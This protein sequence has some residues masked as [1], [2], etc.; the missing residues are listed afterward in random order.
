M[1]FSYAYGV[2]NDYIDKHHLNAALNKEA[3]WRKL[4]ATDKQLDLLRRNNI[5][6]SENITRGEASDLLNKPTPKQLSYIK[7][8]RLHDVPESLTK[9][10]AAAIIGTHKD[11]MNTRAV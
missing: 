1:T 5:E 6:F 10:E 2:C 4:P 3:K 8:F 7:Y 11:I 9:N